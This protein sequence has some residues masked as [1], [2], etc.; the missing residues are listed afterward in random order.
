MGLSGA[1]LAW[2]TQL[3][4]HNTPNPPQIVSNIRKQKQFNIKNVA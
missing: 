4:G 3:K 2:K 1:F